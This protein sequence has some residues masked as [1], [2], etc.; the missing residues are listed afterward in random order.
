[1]PPETVAQMFTQDDLDLLRQAT[2]LVGPIMP[3]DGQT[4]LE[5]VEHAQV[6][7]TGWGSPKISGELLGHAR[8]L[9]LVAHS[10]G[11][12][13]PHVGEDTAARGVRMINAAAANAVP[14]A[15]LTLSLMVS[16]L[17]QVPWLAKCYAAGDKAAVEARRAQCRELMDM[18]IGL[19]SASRVAREVIQLLKS[20]SGLR[21]QIFDPYLT[22]SDAARLGV[23]RVSLEAVL[24]CEVVSIHAPSIP[25]TR[26]MLNARTLPNLPDYAVLI[27]TARGS[28]I[29]EEAL[30][31][32]VRKRPLYVAL[33]VTDPEPPAPDSA[34][35]T[36]ENI[37]LL[38]HVAGA[39]NQSRRAMGRLCIDEVL[40]FLSGEPLTQEVFA[41][42]LATQA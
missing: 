24:K 13:K 42:Q 31:N 17:K 6:V 27:N 1:M 16:L 19:I 4:F 15:Q 30:V 11:T 9:K 29:D 18:D 2:T 35:R 8:R 36:Q 14:V 34:L 37:I 41:H 23:K 39:M 33:D 12:L 5:A 25:A 21:V 10:A 3:K 26:H 20:Y 40:R 7:I 32:E 28:I 22:D 38:P